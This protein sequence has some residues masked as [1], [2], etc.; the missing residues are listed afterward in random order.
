MDPSD[1]L[2]ADIMSQQDVNQVLPRMAYYSRKHSPA[3]CNYE[4]HDKGLLA[5]IR[6]FE[7]RYPKLESAK[8]PILVIT[9]HKSFQYFMKMKCHESYFAYL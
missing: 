2:S 4:I 3:E 1:Y 6:V 9:A 8:H 7:E 5:I